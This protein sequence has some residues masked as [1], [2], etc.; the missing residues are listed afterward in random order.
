MDAWLRAG[1]PPIREDAAA[2]PRAQDDAPDP[3]AAVR[4]DEG[5]TLTG[6]VTAIDRDAGYVTIRTPEGATIQLIVPPFAIAGMRAGDDVAVDVR[7][8]PSSR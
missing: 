4:E 7:V 3:S 1:Q 5:R 2:V 6:R 8:K